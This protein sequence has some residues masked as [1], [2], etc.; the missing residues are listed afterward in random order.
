MNV[1]YKKT[2]AEIGAILDS[3]DILYREFKINET[4]AGLIYLDALSDKLLLE[5]DI[6]RPLL[7][8]TILEPTFEFLTA[9]LKYGEKI[10]TE[11]SFEKAAAAIA[12]GDIVL[13]I[14]NATEFFIL[15]IKKYNHRAVQEPPTETVLKGPRE[16]FIEDIK[17]NLSLL[18]RK[19]KTPKLRIKNFYVGKYSDTTVCLAYID[20]IAD[21]E[22]VN[23]IADKIKAIDID[24]IIGAA[25]IERFVEEHKFSLFNQ[26]GVTEKPDIVMGKLLEG[27][28][29]ILVDGSPIVLTVPYLLFE[30]FQDSYDYY[31]RD[32]RG[33]MLR[34]LRIV[35]AIFS[36]MLPGLYVAI[37][38][39][40]YHLLPL[41]FLISVL[42]AIKGIPFTPPMEMLFVLILFEILHQA[43]VRMPRYV[44]TALSVVGAIVLG[45]TAVNAGLLSS[46]AV[47]IIA[48]SAIG[49]NCVPDL[50]DA[51]SILRVAVLLIGSVLGLFGIIIF[52]VMVIAYLC[53][54]DSYGTPYLA[55]FA[56]SIPSDMKDSIIKDN[57]INM[58]KRPFSISTDNRR[59]LRD[60]DK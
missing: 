23:K 37:Q 30:G 7:D 12:S 56:P 39:Y 31:C 17:V 41:K 32:S 15:S 47:L 29:A 11:V 44:G 50:V 35:G 9:K 36:V 53:S 5:Q 18:R 16:G 38:E 28:I 48:I 25:Y 46:P 55:P 14:D 42:N 22:T 51:F 4:E 57:L 54:L 34:L 33:S 10:K 6:V 26:A 3:D 49:I 19:L 13:A 40:H 59:R 27:R 58:K 8:L 43:S 60:D 21:N 20:G 45:E 2:K 52:T 24:G 1:D